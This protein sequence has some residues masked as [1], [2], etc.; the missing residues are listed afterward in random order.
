MTRTMVPAVFAVLLAFS[1]CA[2]DWPHWRGPARN[3]VVTETSGWNGDAWPRGE[4]W[5]ADVGEGSTSPLVVAGR[6][7]TMGWRGDHDHVVCLDAN[8]GKT[9]WSRQYPC[10]QYGRQAMGDQGIYSGP[11]STPE[12]DADTG[13][14]YTLSTDGDLHCWSTRQQGALVWST[15]LYDSFRIPRR[16]KVGRSGWRDYGYTSSPLVWKEWLIVEVGAVDEGNLV[17]FDKL[18]GAR[19]WTSESRSPAGHN[20]GPVP[21]RVEGV[22]CVAVHNHDGLLVARL[23]PGHAGQTVATHPWGA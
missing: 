12:F 5:S 4:L 7:Y 13:L 14:L 8:S 20:G 9:L 6:V 11:S 21:I 18:T 3:D 22:P 19:R 1:C 10:P 17:A 2:A 15:N 16:P 23:D